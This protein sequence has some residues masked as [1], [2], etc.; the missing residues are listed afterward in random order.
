MNV[1]IPPCFCVSSARAGSANANSVKNQ[2]K[3]S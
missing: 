1:R 2:T 3:F